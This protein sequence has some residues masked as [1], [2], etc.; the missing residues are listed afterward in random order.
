VHP[1]SP[2]KT[3]CRFF[4]R[5][6]TTWPTLVDQLAL[7]CGAHEFN[8]ANVD[9]GG[10]RSLTGW[11]MD[12]ALRGKVA[13][14]TGASRGI[15]RAIAIEL[16]TE[17][18]NLGICS[19][20]RDDLEKVRVVLAP[21]KVEVVAIGADATRAEDVSRV[22]RTVANRLGRIDILV[23]NVGEASPG[24]YGG[25]SVDLTDQDWSFSV[26]VNLLSAVRFTREVAP[27]MQKQGGGAIVNVASIGAYMGDPSSVDYNATKAAVVS[28]SKSMARTLVPKHIRVNCVCPGAV[29][30]SMWEREARAY[31][32]GSPESTA[33]FLKGVADAVPLGRFGRPEEIA[34]VVAFLASEKASFVVGATWDVDG[35]QMVGL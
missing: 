26:D 19:R 27:I 21:N 12:L 3:P 32:D 34:T 15:G 8:I 31:T 7:E 1:S 10:G 17:G 24:T 9:S 18:A 29:E 4:V 33:K 2:L 23:N 22:V 30:T 13:L 20:H 11:E 35:G 28:F 5:L 6:P 14:V 25:K 16:A